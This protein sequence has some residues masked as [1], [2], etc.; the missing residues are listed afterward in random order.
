MSSIP[1]FPAEIERAAPEHARMSADDRRQQLIRVAM[2]LF[3]QKGFTGTTTKEIAHAANVNEAIIFRHFATKD[4]LYRAILDYKANEVCSGDWVDSLRAHA[5]RRDDY[6]LFRTVAENI[7]THRRRDGDNNFLR[8]M[9]YSALEGHTLAEVFLERQARPIHE[10]LMSYIETRQREGAFRDVH[11][12]LAVRAFIGAIHDHFV[13]D[14]FFDKW[15]LDITDEEAIE[16]YTNLLLGGL[17]TDE[18][19]APRRALKTERGAKNNKK[20]V[21]AATNGRAA[22]T[23]AKMRRDAKTKTIKSETTGKKRR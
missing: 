5:E 13:M 12:P 7:F 23:P 18:S 2:Q 10:F 9:L 4:D 22:K 19:T 16:H 3:S 17:L 8:L 6:T 15:H 11:P 1:R 21:R 20:I 14:A